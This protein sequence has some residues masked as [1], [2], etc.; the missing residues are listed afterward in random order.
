[1]AGRS[2]RRKD[3]FREAGHNAGRDLRFPAHR[4]QNDQHFV[5]RVRQLAGAGADSGLEHAV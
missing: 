5:R 4:R 3:A 1:M 2:D